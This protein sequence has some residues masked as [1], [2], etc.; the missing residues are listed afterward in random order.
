VFGLS[1]ENI[2]GVA[3][4]RYF[5]DIGERAALMMQINVFY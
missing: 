4:S 2:M 5:D 3:L 1:F